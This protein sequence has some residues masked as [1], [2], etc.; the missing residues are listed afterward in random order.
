MKGFYEILQ[1]SLAANHEQNQ[2]MNQFNDYL[3]Q[4]KQAHKLSR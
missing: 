1:R 2:Q 3:K 4:I